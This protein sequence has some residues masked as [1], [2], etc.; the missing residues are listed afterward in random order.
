VTNKKKIQNI[1]KSGGRRC[2][3]RGAV[4]GVTSPNVDCPAR[5]GVTGDGVPRGYCWLS[6][7]PEGDNGPT[8]VAL[9]ASNKNN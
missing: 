3:S 8:V 7:C 1:Y 5:D 9:P 2:R 4:P 6:N